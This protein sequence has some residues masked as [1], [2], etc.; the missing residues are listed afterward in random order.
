MTFAISK[1]RFWIVAT[2]MLLIWASLWLLFYLKADEVTKDP[3]SI[4]AK[5]MGEKVTCQT[6]TVIPAYRVYYPN[7]SIAQPETAG[8]VELPPQF[9]LT[10]IRGES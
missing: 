7:G 4:C 3:C 2:V 8:V 6:N 5:K 10:V 9:N 1:D